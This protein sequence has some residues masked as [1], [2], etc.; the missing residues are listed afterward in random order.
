[1]HSAEMKRTTYINFRIVLKEYLSEKKVLMKL[2][3][4]SF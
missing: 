2:A 1:M 4:L 3:G